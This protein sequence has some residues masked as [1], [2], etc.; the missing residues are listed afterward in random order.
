MRPDF[1]LSAE[2]AATVVAMCRQLDGLPLAIELAAARLHVLPVDEIVTRL[3]D[4]F[5]L[6]RRG[7]RRADRHQ[8]LQAAL[9]WSYTL[10]GPAEQTLLRR[11]A[12]FAGGWELTAAEVVCAGDEVAVEAVL[13]LLDELLDRSLVYVQTAQGAPRYGLLETVRQ[14]GAQQLER[15]G[16]ADALRDRHVAWCVALA[17][18]AAP[19]LLGPEQGVWLARLNREHDNLRA[20]LRWTLDRG[21][22]VPGLRL[23]A[24]LWQFWR[25]RSYLSEG[26]RW[27]AAV[28]ALPAEDDAT[29]TA[30]RASALEGAAW[31]TEDEHDFAQASVLFAQSDALRRS[32]GQDERT[33]GLL[34]NAAMEARAHGDYTR[35][36]ALL[37]ESLAQQR[38]WDNRASIKRGGLG[39]ALARL[40]LAEQGQ[41]AR[42]TA[43]YAECLALHRALGDR[44]G[45]GNALLGLGDVARDLGD[46]AQVRAYC[47]ETLALF[48]E[49]GHTWVGFSLNNLALAAYLDG[50]VALA[51]R[52]AEESVVLFR[53]LQASPSLAEALVTLG[54]IR[55]AQGAAAAARTD[56]TEALAL[57]EVAGP[58]VVVAAA[59]DALGVQD[60]RQGEAQRAV[61]FLGAA[62]TL[63]HTMGTPVPPADQPAIE[64]ALAAARASLDDATFTDAWAAGQT[65]PVEQLI[66]Q[67]TAAPEDGVVAPERADG[68]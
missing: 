33:T 19:A 49:L 25:S 20:A 50:D 51:A 34:I 10:L 54:R 32:L 22:S 26:R 45:I 11:L 23:A 55:G 61:H 7:G 43:L 15:V 59:L 52:H 18:Q 44:E 46:T 56:L 68:D 16:E 17:A 47:E 2:N 66:A 53:G 37:E 62:A 58:R 1:V 41:H 21:L 4:R 31:L 36:T 9:D 60:A 28:L 42:A 24:G 48:R 57:A 64:G 29:S 3:D 5:R 6:L 39:L 30:L 8:T 14:Y 65:L 38:A 13:E 63:R 12:V 35:A 67:A 40:A 27:L